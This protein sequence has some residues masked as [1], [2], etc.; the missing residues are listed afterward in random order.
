M[1]AGDRSRPVRAF[2][3]R[4]ERERLVAALAA[5]IAARGYEG[6]TAAL[7]ASRAG[8]DLHAF[9]RYFAGK[10]DCLLAAWDACAEQGFNAAAEAFVATPGSWAEATHAALAA[11]LEFATASA[12]FASLVAVLPYAGTRGL[13]HRDRSLDLFMEFL[14]P[15]YAEAGAPASGART[16]SHM[17]AG[18]VFELIRCY[19]GA[20][21]FH[22][23]P[24]ALPEV[25]LIVLSPFVGREE[26]E[27]IAAGP[28]RRA[29]G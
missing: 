14:E 12:D 27:R 26:A 9:D 18:S 24:D 29:A 4:D 28:V 6:T 11:L 5:L 3:P 15:G 1:S 2:H 7:I 22:E 25:T 19:A 10:E 8:V 16:T 21:R 23:L 20:G 13:V 17:I